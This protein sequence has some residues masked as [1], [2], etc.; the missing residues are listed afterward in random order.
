[1]KLILGAIDRS[2][3]SKDEGPVR[4]VG[5]APYGA[6]QGQYGAPPPQQPGYGGQYGQPLPPG[7]QYGYGQQPPQQHYG[8]LPQGGYGGG[9]PPPAYQGRKR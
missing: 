8:Q 3:D 7:G 6:P 1:V 9:Y 5:G 4:P 2:Y